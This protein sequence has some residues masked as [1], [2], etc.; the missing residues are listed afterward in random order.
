YHRGGFAPLPLHAIGVELRLYR[1]DEIGADQAPG[2]AVPA[3][4]GNLGHHTLDPAVD[5]ADHEDMTTAVARPPDPD[6]TRVDLGDRAGEREGGGVV[7]HLRPGINVLTRLPV[8]RAEVAVVEHQRSEAAR[9]KHLGEPV[10][11][12]LLGG[13]EAR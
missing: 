8:A 2:I 10:K 7:A 13:G 1:G 4:E 5:R 9:R 12:H 6:S 11:G 3:D